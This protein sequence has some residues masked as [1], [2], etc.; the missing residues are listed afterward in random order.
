MVITLL[1]GLLDPVPTNRRGG[2]TGTVGILEIEIVAFA[3]SG[4]GVEGMASL[5]FPAVGI[6]ARSREVISR[7]V[8]SRGFRI[9][10]SRRGLGAEFLT[11]AGKLGTDIGT[12]RSA[13]F[14]LG[15]IPTLPTRTLADGGHARIR[16]AAKSVAGIGSDAKLAGLAGLV[17]NRRRRIAGDA[18]SSGAWNVVVRAGGTRIGRSVVAHELAR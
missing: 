13:A 17:A 5:A 14:A 9:R 12:Q 8:G 10:G 4:G 6:R 7:A 2:T 11:C 16:D 3:A 1:T 18:C 15:T